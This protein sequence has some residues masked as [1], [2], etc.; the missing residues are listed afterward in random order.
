MRDTYIRPTRNSARDYLL[1][2]I[3]IFSC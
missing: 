3:L 1:P 2:S